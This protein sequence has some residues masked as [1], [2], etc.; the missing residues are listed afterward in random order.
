MIKNYIK[1]A[2]RNIIKHK[3]FSFI[4]IVGL[5][6]GIACSVLILLFVTHEL[7]FDKFH[8]RADDIYRIAVRA[9]IGD[10]PIRQT[11][12]SSETFRKLILDFP[13][14]E[15]GVKFLNLGDTPIQ[16]GEK[17]FYESRFFAVDET[18]Y[19]IFSVPLLYGN[20]KTVLKNPNTMVV[21]KD[22]AEKYFGIVD[23]VGRILK[24]NFSEG[25][26][27]LDFEITGVSENMPDNS[28][29]HY[30]LICS[31]ASF[32]SY[33]NN[34]GWSSNNFVTYLLLHEGSSQKA[35]DEKLK[36]FTRKYMG[37]ERYDAWVAKG[38]SWEY[39]LQPITQIHLTSDL[40]GELEANGNQ[41][42]V[43]VFSV[44]SIIILLIACINF[45]NLS[46]AK[47]SLRAKEVGMRKVV[48]SGKSRLVA[49][50]IS[51]SVI[52]S[53]I[54][55]VLGIGIV[56]LL[57]PPFRNL[58]GRPLEM[59]YLS[60]PMTIPLLLGLGIF[61]GLVSGSYPAFFL[62]S[63]KPI[64]ALKDRGL[65]GVSRAGTRLRNVLV[66]FQFSISIFL[67]IGTVVVFQQMRFLR[68]TKLGFEKEQVLVIS[69]A[70]VLGSRTDS[71]KETLRQESGIIDVSGANM[72]PGMGFS[73]IGFGAEGVEQSFTLNM[74]ICDQ[75]YLKTLGLEMK[76]GR[77]FSKDYPSDANAAVINEKA[78]ELMGWD[79]P[80]GKKINNWSQ[81]RGNFTV[82]G[83]VKDFHYESFH[84]K[85]RPFALFLAGGYYNRPHRVIAVRLGTG[86]LTRTI[87]AIENKWTEFAP[88]NPFEYSFL[89]QDYDNLYVNE[90]Q[91][92]KM[93]TAFSFLA[94]LIA[95]LGLFGLASFIVD[96]RT[97]EIGIR[98]VLGASV[99]GVVSL[100]NGSFLKWVLL[101]NFLA[102]PAAFFIMRGWLQ[103][104]AYRIDLSLWMF[105]PA[106]VLAL[107]IAMATVS[108][109][110]VKAAFK[111]PADSLRF[112]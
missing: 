78:L 38:N 4:N 23:V 27:P 74:G 98:K 62:S 72:L 67:I 80:I 53:F 106:A 112:E 79:D 85:I 13:E 107:L 81:N 77:F 93:F 43:Y 65:G 61:V 5:A 91:T 28:H 97:R 42:Y 41:T 36:D 17:I 39:Y 69:N 15:A 59:N 11:Y 104:F 46:T 90:Q 29:F 12:S 76:Q 19:D 8:E 33:I 1:V 55:L 20:P 9:S 60:N 37:G 32:P 14:I 40:N 71:F 18:F 54:A 89:D 66:V 25:S 64:A 10:T 103:N 49:Q 111:N 22:T 100:L 86:D 101:A 109:Q 92:R 24:A 88:A 58:V 50:F 82:V 7:S 56:H 34:T 83:V 52:L 2:L 87:A 30:D 47:S 84:Q 105:V 68:N 108:F 63:F 70:D 16:S 102:W 44:V 6:V 31:S 110:T 21:T 51:E 96:R 3:G 26:G 35:F 99:P 95:C 94:I 57:L 73:N 75:D 48:G 45:M